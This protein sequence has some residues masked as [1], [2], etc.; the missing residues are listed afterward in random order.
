[1]RCGDTPTVTEITTHHATDRLPNRLLARD[2][3]KR[4]GGGSPATS[5]RGSRS[6]ASGPPPYMTKHQRGSRGARAPRAAAVAVRCGGVGSCHWSQASRVAPSGRTHLP[7]RES[8]LKCLAQ[9]SSDPPVAG[10]ASLGDQSGA[11]DLDRVRPPGDVE[12]ASSPRWPVT[13]HPPPAT[14]A[15]HILTPISTQVIKPRLARRMTR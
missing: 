15:A 5:R 2:L 4:T 13:A 14:T 6:D 3:L 11:D 12:A 8:A 1:F 7:Q 10:S 9:V